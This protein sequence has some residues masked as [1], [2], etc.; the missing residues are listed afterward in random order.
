[1]DRL[2]SLKREL[3][4]PYDAKYDK[5][6]DS[7]QLRFEIALERSKKKYLET[8]EVSNSCYTKHSSRINFVD[9]T[10]PAVV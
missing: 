5:G 7:I 9:V 3:Q 4:N 2:Q 1:M 6:V 8:G 10:Y